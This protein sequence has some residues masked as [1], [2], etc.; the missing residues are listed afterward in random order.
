MGQGLRCI[1]ILSAAVA[2]LYRPTT[3]SS[4]Y[5]LSYLHRYIYVCTQR[6]YIIIIYT[7]NINIIYMCMYVCY[8]GRTPTDVAFIII[9]VR[10]RRRTTLR[11][12]LRHSIMETQ[13]LQ[14]T[15][16]IYVCIH[17]YIHTFFPL[18]AA[19]RSCPRPSSCPRPRGTDREVFSRVCVVGGST[20]SRARRTTCV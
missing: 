14:L 17:I 18:I 16:P 9:A 15:S 20:S 13:P 8:E 11:V 10:E 4:R 7:S 12:N 1:A 19:I 3:V 6:Y 2:Q 5:T